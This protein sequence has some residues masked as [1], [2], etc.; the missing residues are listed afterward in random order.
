MAYR[1][2]T[3]VAF[4]ARGTTNPTA[5]DIKYY[6][7]MKMWDASK[8]IEFGF[9]DSH[10]K[11]AAVRD[12]SK[13]LT[14]KRRLQER[15]DNS[16]QLVLI[17]TSDTKLD[18]DWVPFEITYAIDD[19]K[20]PIIAVY[21]GYRAVMDPNQLFRLWPPALSARILNGRANVVHIPFKKEPLLDAIGQFSVHDKSPSG[22]LACYTA[23]SHRNWDLMN[24]YEQGGNH[25][26]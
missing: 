12:S 2:G 3:Y 23:S 21:P 20:L 19:K 18:T 4:H 10:D 17:V 16:K 25:R 26:T 22:P 24:L 11:T 5:S 6:N 14:L 7:T 15:L 1:S 13:R 8:T 9:T